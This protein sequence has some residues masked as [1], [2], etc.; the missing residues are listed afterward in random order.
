MRQ[1]DGPLR[2][3]ANISF[4]KDVLPALNAGAEGVGLYRTE[5][6]FMVAGR[7][8]DETE[9]YLLYKTVVEALAG[10]PAYIRLLDI[11]KEKNF[12]A[13]MTS[14]G[15]RPFPAP[16]GARFLLGHPEILATQ[17][18]ALA[19][20]SQH[21]AINVVYPFVSDVKQFLALKELFVTSVLGVSSGDIRH[22][23]MFELPSICLESRR[24]FKHSDFGAIGTNDL[25][26]YL[27][28]LDQNNDSKLAR[29]VS[30][31]PILRSLIKKVAATAFKADR[32]LLFCGEL[33]KDPKNLNW[34][35]Q[36]G[37]RIISMPP[38]AIPL[39]RQMIQKQSD[40][41]I[42]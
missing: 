36:A 39:V 10:K 16:Y 29:K 25:V 11:H 20:A 32:P 15:A 3:M 27:F 24:V 1:P 9:Q 7:L 5:F 12:P 28:G 35:L 31:H 6:E 22:G 17:A 42:P 14:Y 30:H 23:A 4:A 2:L 40:S 38:E 41:N 8:L 34:L 18:R 13:F 33:A 26:R 19:R 37:I 21:G